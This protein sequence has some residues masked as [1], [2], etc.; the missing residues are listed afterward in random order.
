MEGP[1]LLD[2]LEKPFHSFIDLKAKV[3]SSE[4]RK[5]NLPVVIN[6]PRAIHSTC[7]QEKLCA[8]PLHEGNSRHPPGGLLS[9]SE[10]VG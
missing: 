1:D 8:S 4:V 10:Q 2:P 3:K 5:K 9:G 6:H 7:R